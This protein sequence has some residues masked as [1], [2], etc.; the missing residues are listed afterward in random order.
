M[1]EVAKRFLEYVSYDTQSQ[2]EQNVIP[3]TK[4]QLILAKKLA[5]ELEG[6]GAE[7]VRI[8]DQ[9]Y[10]YADIPATTNKPA[11]VLGF[12]AHMD[13]APSFSGKDVKPKVIENYD[14]KS[15]CLNPDLD[16]WMTAEDFP[17]LK[18]VNGQTLITT[19]GNTLLGA[20]DKAGI[21]EILTMA[22]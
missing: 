7:N 9:G 8:T 21:A 5:E 6:M 1:S 22:D 19:D 4:K 17:D 13:T 20:D 12:I 3:S 11:P 15:I 16:I 10:V 2:E 14:G 18:H